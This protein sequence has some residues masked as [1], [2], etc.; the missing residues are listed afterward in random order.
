MKWWKDNNLPK[1]EES[2]KHLRALEK[3][4]G[5]GHDKDYRPDEHYYEEK[6]P[7]YLP[8]TLHDE[9][10]DVWIANPR[11]T[12]YSRGHHHLTAE[13]DHEYYGREKYWDYGVEDLALDDLPAII[14]KILR[15]RQSEHNLCQKV[16]VVTHEK[17]GNYALLLLNEYPTTSHERIQSLVTQ[18]PCFYEDRK[19]YD[20]RY[21]HENKYYGEIVHHDKKKDELHK[22]KHKE[23]DEHEKHDGEAPP[24]PHKEHDAKK[25]HN[26]TAKDN[27]YEGAKD[28]DEV[29]KEKDGEEGKHEKEKGDEHKKEEK[30]V[31]IYA[32]EREL[33]KYEKHRKQ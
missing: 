18:A 25:A 9:G 10:Y 33:P 31:Y 7:L 24:N 1:D 14:D 16:Q 20:K 15:V 4:D 27:P 5:K 6:S 26:N 29:E 2:H 3:T 12:K 23:H 19:I 21:Y 28:K 17:A 13:H 32:W 22:D 30:E 11:G 8:E